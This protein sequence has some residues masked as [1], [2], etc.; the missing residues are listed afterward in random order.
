MY[1]KIINLKRSLNKLLR[2]HT[3]TNHKNTLKLAYIHDILKKINNY[4]IVKTHTISNYNFTIRYCNC[5]HLIIKRS[6][7]DGFS[8]STRTKAP[9]RSKENHS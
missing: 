9:G 8:I 5:Q 4:F 7:E 1:F 3:Y 6:V 2:D